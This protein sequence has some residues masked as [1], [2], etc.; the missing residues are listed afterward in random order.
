MAKLITEDDIEQAILSKLKA[1]PFN[2]DIIIC[3]SDPAKRED[4]NDGTGRTS[5]KQC[6]LPDVLKASLYRINPNIEKDKL[7]SFAKELSKDFTGT[8]FVDTNY[9]N[10]RLIR[11]GRKISVRR[12]GKEDFDFIKL[13]DFNNP[14]NNTFTAISQMWIQ[15]GITTGEDRMC[16]YSSTAF[17][18]CSSN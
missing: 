13:V 6:V 11:D 9:K 5:K 17:R 14:E 16:W 2:Y 12:N 15:G 7:D 1:E 8:D 4:L 10:Y 3:D 18:W